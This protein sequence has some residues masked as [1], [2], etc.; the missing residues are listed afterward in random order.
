MSILCVD[1]YLMLVFI[2][3]IYLYRRKKY[4]ELIDCHSGFFWMFAIYGYQ[5]EKI[6]KDECKKM[7]SHCFKGTFYQDISGKKRPDLSRQPS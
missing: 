6:E 2:S 3:Q 5:K 1:S 7:I 4:R